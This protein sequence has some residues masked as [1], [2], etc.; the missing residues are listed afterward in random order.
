MDEQALINA[1]HAFLGAGAGS[2]LVITIAKFL[3]QRISKSIEVHMNRMED[4][5]TKTQETL[6]KM[7]AVNVKLELLDH[8]HI[9]I[10]KI[11]E[12]VQAHDKDI[13]VIMERLDRGKVRDFKTVTN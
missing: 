1:L 2:G 8:H 9:A 12:L 13:A 7:S 11:S 5:S 6:Q 3:Y 10:N 4:L